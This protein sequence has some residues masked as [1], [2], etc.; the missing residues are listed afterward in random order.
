MEGARGTVSVGLGLQVLPIPQSSHASPEVIPAALSCPN[1][2]RQQALRWEHCQ[3]A[4]PLKNFFHFT[5][6]EL[7]RRDEDKKSANVISEHA[8]AGDG[9]VCRSSRPLQQSHIALSLGLLPLRIPGY[10]RESFFSL[11]SELQ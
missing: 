3:S 8:S 1:E 9:S 7:E 6:W 5:P 2:Y 11:K 4:L 10:L